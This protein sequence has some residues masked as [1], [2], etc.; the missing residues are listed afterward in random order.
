MDKENVVYIPNE[1]VFSHEKEGILPLVTMWM[2]FEGTVISEISQ[3]ETNTVYYLY[4]ESKKVKLT[5]AESGMV[6]ASSCRVRD[7]WSKTRNFQL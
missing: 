7:C 5:E 6:V 3:R 2:D 4:T 1:I